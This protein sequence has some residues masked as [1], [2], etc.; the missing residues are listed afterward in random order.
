MEALGINLPFL[1]AQIVNFLILLALLSRFAYKP[2]LKMLDERAAK[3]QESLEASEKANKQAEEAEVVFKERIREA[4]VQGQLILDRAAKT[5]EE[6]RFKAA[7]DA[8]EEASIIVA[9]AHEE[10]DREKAETVTCLCQEYAKLVTLAAGK[11]IGKTLD[12]K[13]HEELINRVL[14]ESVSLRKN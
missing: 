10:I 12:E 14:E 1:I 9:R 11:V 3:I 7:E 13:A 6:M 2:V 4:S 5:G 8:K